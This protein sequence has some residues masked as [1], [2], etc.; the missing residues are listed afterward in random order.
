MRALTGGCSWEFAARER[1][2]GRGQVPRCARVRALSGDRWVVSS[3]EIESGTPPAEEAPVDHRAEST[4]G[5]RTRLDA[6]IYASNSTPVS[7]G[8]DSGM[9]HCHDPR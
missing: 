2:L 1:L 3:S 5:R 9:E 7:G 8:A 4:F 6:A